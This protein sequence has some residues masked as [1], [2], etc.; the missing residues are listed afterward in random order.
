M[1]EMKLDRQ[2]LYIVELAL[3]DIVVGVYG[4]DSYRMSEQRLNDLS[5]YSRKEFAK[6]RDRLDVYKKKSAEENFP[7]VS[8]EFSSTELDLMKFA[9]SEMLHGEYAYG[10]ELQTVV[11]CDVEEVEAMIKKI[12]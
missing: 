11:G 7:A 2:E 6:L 4:N 8:Y 12:A 9:L 1:R 3:D 5:G 10:S